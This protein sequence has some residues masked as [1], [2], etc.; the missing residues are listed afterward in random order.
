MF[1]RL[2][3]ATIPS[4]LQRLTPPDF[5]ATGKLREKKKRWSHAWLCSL[6]TFP[7]T[8]GFHRNNNHI[9]PT[10]LAPSP[11]KT[12]SKGL[13]SLETDSVPEAVKVK[14]EI[15][16]QWLSKQENTKVKGCQ[17]TPP[18]Q[19]HR[20]MYLLRWSGAEGDKQFCLHV[21]CI[22]QMSSSRRG[23]VSNIHTIGNIYCTTGNRHY[24]TV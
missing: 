14:K 17:S 5:C 22:P 24:T 23:C 11:L 13:S 1:G 2:P 7:P 20:K 18:I 15:L 3:T 9:K 10:A 19:A 4:E 6:G 16:W 21:K 8:C 12:A